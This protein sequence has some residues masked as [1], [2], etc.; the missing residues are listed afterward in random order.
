MNVIHKTTVEYAESR[1]SQ[2]QIRGSYSTASQAGR[3]SHIQVGRPTSVA[4][5]RTHAPLGKQPSGHPG[6]S[7][8][9]TLALLRGEECRICRIEVQSVPESRFEQYGPSA[10]ARLSHIHFN[11]IPNKNF[12]NTL[13]YMN[14]MIHEIL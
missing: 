1:Y 12:S 6:P 14:N 10:A 13:S 9:F 3:L 7:L 4:G 5:R 8:S 11:Y 2:Y